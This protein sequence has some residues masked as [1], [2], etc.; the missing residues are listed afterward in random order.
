M[1]L[2]FVPK[3]VVKRRWTVFWQIREDQG[4]VGRNIST[5][6]VFGEAREDVTWLYK[7]PEGRQT[8]VGSAE[9][10]SFRT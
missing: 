3:F 6:S 9:D 4:N 2:R 8:P 1:L 10:R 5:K 7:Y